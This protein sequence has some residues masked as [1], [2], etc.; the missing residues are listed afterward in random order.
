MIRYS[1]HISSGQ[2][3]GLQYLS[4]QTGM[5]VSDHLRRAIDR[6]LQNPEASVIQYIPFISGSVQPA[7]R[8]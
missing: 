6:Y 2:L 5:A 3:Y 8:S 1:F 7:Y 4:Q